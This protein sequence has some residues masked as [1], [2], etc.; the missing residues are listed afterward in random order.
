MNLCYNHFWERILVSLAVLTLPNHEKQRISLPH[1]TSAVVLV[2]VV[3]SNAA[4]LGF[5]VPK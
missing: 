4:V 2:A 1:W 3:R 5:N